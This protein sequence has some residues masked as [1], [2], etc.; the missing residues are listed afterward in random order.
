MR[1][2]AGGYPPTMNHVSVR[3]LALVC[4]M[5]LVLAGCTS[6]G[7]DQPSEPPTPTTTTTETTTVPVRQECADVADTASALVTAAGRLVTGDATVEQVRTAAGELSDA[8]D[9]ARAAARPEVGAN[10][11]AA[12]QA[13]QR[14]RDALGAQPLDRA[15]LRTAAR[16]LLDSLGDA[17]AICS[18]ASP[19]VSSTEP[20]AT[21]T[22]AP[23]S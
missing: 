11:D 21:G 8:L 16:D 2:P 22:T 23:T 10:L 6:S 5:T 14:M 18:P 13:L 9:A 15:G 4:G 17:A 19:T 12:G 20:T 1:G 7:G 3:H